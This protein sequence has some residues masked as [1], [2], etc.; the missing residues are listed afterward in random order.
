VNADNSTGRTLSSWADALVNPMSQSLVA[1]AIAGLLLASL[2]VVVVLGRPATYQ[3]NDVLL[4]DQTRAL[5]LSGEGVVTKLVLLRAKY[6]GLLHTETILRPVSEST[7]IPIGE[8]NASLRAA[9]P[10]QSLLVNVIAQNRDPKRAAQLA[11]AG[12]AQLTKYLDDEQA[13]ANIPVEDRITLKT[14]TAARPGG[15]VTP[16]GK[17]A[18]SAAVVAG[19]IG[20]V[21]TYVVVQLFLGARHTR[22]PETGSHTG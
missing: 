19:L 11:T 21:I 10:P 7:G 12:A 9:A 16:T 13:G 2:S 18:F 22:D 5:S 6:A 14:V 20:L 1:A 17:R 15:K 8:V 4:I 3:S